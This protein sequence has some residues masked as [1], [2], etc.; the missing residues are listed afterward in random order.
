MS[1]SSSLTFKFILVGDSA[2]GKTSMSR[3][4]CEQVFDEAQPQTI[5]LEFGNR[6]ID[7]KGTPVR[8]QLWDTAGQ[9]RFR[10]ITRSYFRNSVAVFVVFDVSNRDSF[11]GL[12][13]WIDDAMN[14]APAE[15]IKVLVGNKSDLFKRSVSEGEAMD[16][17]KQN[18][19]MYFETSAL[20]G[21]KIEETFITVAHKYYD[22]LP[23]IRQLNN[24]NESNDRFDDILSDIKLEK[25]G[26]SSCCF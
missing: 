9:E 3:M 23:S 19:F 14:L 13:K 24:W 26:I 12:S 1:G 6:T 8:I 5:A 22:S 20:S 4:F 18:G 17:A 21:H 25:P 7:I 16:Y 11:V 10:S 15:S 2:V